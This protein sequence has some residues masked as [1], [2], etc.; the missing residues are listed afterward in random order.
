ML[1]SH[2]ICNSS[3]YALAFAAS[4]VSGIVI[5]LTGCP[6]DVAAVRLYN[7]GL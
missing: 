4:A 3:P 7:Q 2:G 6:I 5:V 1:L